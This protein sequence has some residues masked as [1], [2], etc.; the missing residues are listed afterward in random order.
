LLVYEIEQKEKLDLVLRI[1]QEIV[2][3]KSV[4]LPASA[5]EDRY[6]SVSFFNFDILFIY[7]IF[8]KQCI[9]VKVR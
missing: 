4:R 8:F 2:D 6:D 9:C 3:V 1:T 5:T 7:D